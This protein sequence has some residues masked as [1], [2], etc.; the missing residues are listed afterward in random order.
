MKLQLADIAK[1]IGGEIDGDPETLI[2]GA[3]PFDEAGE[4]DLALAGSKPYLKRLEETRAG[5]VIVPPGNYETEKN[6]ILA[7]NPQ[8]AF[9]RALSLLFPKAAATS[10]ISTHACLGKQLSIGRDVSIGPFTAVG[11]R[12]TIGNRVRI[13]SHV[14]IGNNVTIGDDVEIF[15]NVTILDRCRIGNRVIIQGGTVIGSE[16]FGFAPE[17]ERYI[18]IPH[19]GIVQIDDDVEIGPGN[20]I[21]R[22]TFGKTWIQCGVKTGSLVHVAHNV[23]VGENTILVAQVGISGSVTIGKHVVLAGQAGVAGHLKI[24]DY[25]MVGP[26]AGVSRSV[27]DGM[28]VSGTP[29]MPHKVWLRTQRIVPMLPEIK[30]QIAAM[31]K[32]LAALEKKEL[33]P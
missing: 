1:T 25:A 32:R 27:S 12:V 22:A 15:P 11:D 30:K 14:A 31:E 6:L 5:A 28:L 26:Q 13:H 16:G 23:T 18:R 2:S 29:E 21:D 8:A 3:G 24:G 9:A 33:D 7:T 4:G 19:T 20:T 10:E 17:G